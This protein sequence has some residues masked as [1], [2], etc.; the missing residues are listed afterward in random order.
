MKFKRTTAEHQYIHL[1]MVEE[2]D[3]L[4]SYPAEKNP[5]VEEEPVKA[6]V[7]TEETE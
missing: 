7:A 5:V 3:K 2:H 1:A 4:P 6:P